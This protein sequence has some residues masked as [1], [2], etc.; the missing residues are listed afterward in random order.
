MLTEAY[1]RALSELMIRK[2]DNDKSV[3]YNFH[4]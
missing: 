3:N 4:P 2:N 1:T